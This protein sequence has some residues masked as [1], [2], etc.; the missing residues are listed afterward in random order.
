MNRER[1]GNFAVTEELD[2]LVVVTDQAGLDE[3][4]A[5]N[6]IAFNFCKLADID[7]LEL[8]AEI[9][10]VKTTAGKLAVEGHLTALK[11]DANTA[12]GTGLLTFVAFTGGFTMA[13]TLPAPETLSGM[14][15]TFDG[16]DFIEIHG[17]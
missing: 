3:G 10:V 6:G 12:T 2:T 7:G 8:G 4:L 9:E 13:A 16:W 5:V 11:T 15:S 14:R 17:F 1:L